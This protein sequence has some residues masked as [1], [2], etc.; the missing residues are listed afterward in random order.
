MKPIKSKFK[1]SELE[2]PVTVNRISEK[3]ENNPVFPNPPQ[4][5]ADLKTLLPEFNTALSNAKGRDMAMVSIKNDKKAELIGKIQEVADYV[6]AISKGDRTIILLSGFYVTGESRS[7]SQAPI[8]TTLE[9][10]LGLSGEATVRSRNVKGVKSYV[11]QF[12][13]EAPGPNTVWVNQY[14][15]QGI[16][17]FKGLSSEKRHWFRVIAVGWNEQLSYSPIVSKVIQ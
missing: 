8:I 10:E 14:S 12:C 7:N 4:A 13:T 16:Y 9:V 1:K 11:H 6:T 3:I 5:L 17:I 15:S 2:L